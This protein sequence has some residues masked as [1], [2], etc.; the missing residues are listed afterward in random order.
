MTDHKITG[1]EF[2]SILILFWLGSLTVP[3]RL[4]YGMISPVRRL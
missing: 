3:D 4:N 2:Q 1:I